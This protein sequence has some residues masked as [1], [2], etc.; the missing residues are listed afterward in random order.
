MIHAGWHLVVKVHRHLWV[1]I[2]G[3]DDTPSTGHGPVSAVGGP[4][5]SCFPAIRDLHYTLMAVHPAILALYIGGTADTANVPDVFM[6]E[7][8]D[9]FALILGHSPPLHHQVAV[10][11]I[12]TCSQT[13]HMLP[14]ESLEHAFLTVGGLYQPQAQQGQHQEQKQ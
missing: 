9:A 7:G 2:T 11:V 8:V 14:Q 1:T 10:A 13:V 12:A 3:N 6:D 4:G 5:T